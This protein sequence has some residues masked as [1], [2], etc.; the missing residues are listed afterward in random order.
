MEVP[1]FPLACV[2][3]DED[4][5]YLCNVTSA[6]NPGCSSQ[7]SECRCF[8][9]CWWCWGCCLSQQVPGCPGTASWHSTRP[10]EPAP[11]CSPSMGSAF[12][13]GQAVSPHP[14]RCLGGVGLRGEGSGSGVHREVLWSGRKMRACG[15]ETFIWQHP[16]PCVGEPACKLWDILE[17]K[18]CSQS[19]W[20]GVCR[21]GCGSLELGGRLGA[22]R[23]AGAGAAPGPPAAEQEEAAAEMRTEPYL[24]LGPQTARGCLK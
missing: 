4:N 5:R 1:V 14:M 2:N 10:G 6:V 20:A 23:G 15:A 8:A 12:G 18:D 16:E 11:C 3:I 7:L 13:R 19:P 9:W 24:S 22:V 21:E 17:E